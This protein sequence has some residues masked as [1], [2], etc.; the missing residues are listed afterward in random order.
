LQ[1]LWDEGRLEAVLS[2]CHL[3]ME[4]YEPPETPDRTVARGRE[5]ALR[6]LQ[7]WMSTWSSY[8]YEVVDMRSHGDKVLVEVR[9]RM[10]GAASGLPI[11]MELFQI[12][13]VREGLATRMEMYTDRGQA[14]EASGL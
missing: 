5:N 11:S 6:A 9:Q 7:T 3:E 12:W 2:L 14:L 10:E 1:E 4:W 13:T 8:E